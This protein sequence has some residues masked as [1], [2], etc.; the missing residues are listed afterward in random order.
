M[1]ILMLGLAGSAM[2]ANLSVRPEIKP[3]GL[4]YEG[5]EP[6]QGGETIANATV[7]GAL[8]YTDSG[9]TTG[10]VS[11]YVPTCVSSSTA[12]DVVY[13]FTP[14]ADIT[15]DV[16]LCGST[17]DT[18]LEI[19]MD[20]AGNSI[21]CNDDFCGL[22]S[23]IDNV[24]LLGG[25]NY[26]FIVDGYSSG[27]GAY[28]INVIP[29]APTGA[30]CFGSGACEI[31][32]E[33]NCSAAGGTYYGDGSV[34]EPNP[35]PPPPPIE[36]PQGAYIE[37]EPQ[38]QDD[39]VDSYNGGCNSTPNVFQDLYAQADDCATMCGLICTYYYSG[40]SY[41]DTDWYRWHAVG[42]TVT[43]T[44]LCNFDPF[45]AIVYGTNCNSLGYTYVFGLAFT[46]ASISYAFA[47]NQEG[48]TIMLTQVFGTGVPAG[49]YTLDVCGI[50]GPPTPEGACCLSTGACF[51][52]TE[53]NCAL[54]GGI[55]QGDDTVC[56]PQ[57][58]IPVPTVETS[59]GAVKNLYN[60]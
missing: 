8:P 6:R 31:D 14:G 30:C 13:V 35:C 42:G 7:I 23:E 28:T 60:N 44:A 4:P 48:W 34:C 47:A 17:Y 10:Y 26:Y 52:F 18:V 55:Y 43:E 36:C 9:T 57:T 32:N 5:G 39:Y 12:P 45:L 21:G 51:I 2:A 25:H 46:P 58:C 41:R 24:A 40:L 15:V 53:A 59:W 56:T 3:E 11:D 16:S 19:Y 29:S 50:T 22:Q 54:A 1:V 27:N 49:E 38:C 20:A 37:G 33:A